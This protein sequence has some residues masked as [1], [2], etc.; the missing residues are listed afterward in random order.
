MSGI[1]NKDMQNASVPLDHPKRSY[2]VLFSLET[3]ENIELLQDSYRVNTSAKR[4]QLDQ[5]QQD[6][7]DQ[8]RFN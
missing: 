8:I 5:L 4:K 1:H 2:P 3:P 7:S 6:I